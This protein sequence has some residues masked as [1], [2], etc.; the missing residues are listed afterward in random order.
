M[1]KKYYRMCLV[2][3]RRQNDRDRETPKTYLQARKHTNKITLNII[4]KSLK[5]EGRVKSVPETRRSIT[6]SNYI[7][8]LRK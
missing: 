3:A 1:N 5:M 8:T 2:H 4:K 7:A 6:P